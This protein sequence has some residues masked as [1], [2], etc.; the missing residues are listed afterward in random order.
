MQLGIE[1][2]YEWSAARN[3]ETDRNEVKLEMEYIARNRVQQVI[4]YSK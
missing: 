2:S 3:I 1:C 4:E